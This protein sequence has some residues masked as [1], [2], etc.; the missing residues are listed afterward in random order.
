MFQASKNSKAASNPRAS[1]RRGMQFIAGVIALAAILGSTACAG[2]AE[3]GDLEP[4]DSVS[5]KWG[6]DGENGI[7]PAALQGGYLSRSNT[8][9]A[10]VTSPLNASLIELC[11]SFNGTLCILKTEWEHWINPTM[12]IPP[13]SDSILR[14]RI[15]EALIE[16]AMD[17]KVTVRIG[18]KID[19]QGM[20]GMYPAWTTNRLGLLEQQTMSAFIAIKVNA[21][22]AAV[23]IGIVGPGPGPN[24]T[25]PVD[26]PRFTY[27]EAVFY[28]NLFG[29]NPG[30]MMAC[31]GAQVATTGTVVGLAD[32]IC[33][34]PGNPCNIDG[35]GPCAQWCD[36]W[37]GVGLPTGEYCAI[38]RDPM[39]VKWL[40][41][42]TVYM[43]VDPL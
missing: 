31:S 20:F 6:P 1:V 41:P 17:P 29:A 4:I 24:A 34:D 15:V 18:G 36:L 37:G 5:Q 32:R 38:A 35:L 11:D 12:T 2:G 26:D 28:G 3:S 7:P 33:S 21:F 8:D 22:G 10:S 19:V 30:K 43:R 9:A 27:Q 13:D 42:I 14:G 16:G 25:K 23:P 39:G 40:F